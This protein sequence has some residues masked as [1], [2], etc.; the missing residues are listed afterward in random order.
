MER[1][2]HRFNVGIT[3][4]IRKAAQNIKKDKYYDVSYSEMWRDLIRLG[5]KQLEEEER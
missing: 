5:I 3:D 2:T 1:I 4:E